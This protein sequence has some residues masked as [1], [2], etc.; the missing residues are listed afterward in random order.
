[1]AE[2][3]VTVIGENALACF[4]IIVYIFVMLA[5]LISIIFCQIHCNK[6]PDPLSREKAPGISIL[7]PLVGIDPNLADNLESFFKTNYPRYEL[8]ICVHDELDPAVSVVRPL[9]EKYPNVDCQLLIGGKKVGINP[10]VNN[11]M[12]GYLVSK[13]DLIMVSDAGCQ[14]TDHSLP[15]LVH[16]M[17]DDVGLVHQMPYTVHRKGFASTVEMVYFGGAHARMYLSA[18]ALG[19]NCVTGMSSMMRKSILED[20]GGLEEFGQYIAE[21]YFMGKACTDRGFKVVVSSLWALQNSGTYSLSQ[22]KRRMARWCK[23]RLSM[24]P[25][26]IVLDPLTECL[27]LG[28]FTA[29]GLYHL[30]HLHPVVF[31]LCHLLGWFLMDYIQLSGVHNQALPFNKSEFAVAWITREVLTIFAYVEAL[32]DPNIRWR[33]GTFRMKWGGKAVEVTS[34]EDVKGC[35]CYLV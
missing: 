7:K 28:L 19:I 5:H 16:H 34:E 20:A 11:M 21:D 30:L 17:K 18:N 27:A 32:L 15:D 12:P 35:R 24:L 25:L 6:N 29:W 10:K 23:L 3:S 31:F 22:F 33:T 9:M 13:Y 4:A 2:Y 26:L 8:L 1:M 14:I